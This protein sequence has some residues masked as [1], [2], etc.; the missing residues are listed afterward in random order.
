M[1]CV[2]RASAAS[3]LICSAIVM[4][5]LTLGWRA[6]FDYNVLKLQSRGLESVDTELRLLKADAESTIFASVVCDDLVQTRALH[7]R[8]AR[9]STVAAVHSIAEL[10]LYAI[11]KGVIS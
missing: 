3:A 2:N 10:I 1:S 4:A 11:R 5:A 6:K 7:Q 9:L 8:L